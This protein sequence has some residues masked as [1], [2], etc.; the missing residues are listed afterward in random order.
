[1]TVLW[2]GRHSVNKNHSQI[3]TIAPKQR[4][5]IPLRRIQLSQ[6]VNEASLTYAGMSCLDKPPTP[7]THSAG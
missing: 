7:Q 2:F 3:G 6:V 1:M 5:V 4:K